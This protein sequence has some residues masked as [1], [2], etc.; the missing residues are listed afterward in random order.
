[1]NENIAPAINNPVVSQLK[2]DVNKEF[3]EPPI[4]SVF[5]LISQTGEKFFLW[6]R[7][8]DS[9]LRKDQIPKDNHL[10]HQFCDLKIGSFA[11]LFIIVN[12]FKFFL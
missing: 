11:F 6:R 10:F 2:F 12:N 3:I 7:R 4:D 1:L 8:N 5:G 9:S